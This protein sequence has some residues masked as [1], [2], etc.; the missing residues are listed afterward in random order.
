MV[1]VGMDAEEDA[2][3]TD[4]GDSPALLARIAALEADNQRL[5][6]KKEL[7][8]GVALELEDLNDAAQ[9]RVTQL[10]RRIQQ[11]GDHLSAPETRVV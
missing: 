11:H 6:G 2:H 7:C 9:A 10:E 5:E 4:A 3:G 1:S 8:R